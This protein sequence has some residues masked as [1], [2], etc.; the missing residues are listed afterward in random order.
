MS[1]FRKVR[2]HLAL[3]LIAAAGG[4][5]LAAAR[6]HASHTGATDAAYRSLGVVS[7]EHDGYRYEFHA[8]SGQEHLFD[9]RDD[10]RCLADVAASHPDVVA[11]CR[12]ELLASLGI[13]SLD[14]LRAPYADTIRRLEA[15]GYL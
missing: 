10:P 11:T 4:A 13:R 7:T 12:S 8:P 14:D 3:A 9:L 6:S 5:A 2:V 1:S 15:M